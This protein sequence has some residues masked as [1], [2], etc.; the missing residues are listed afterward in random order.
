MGGA[1]GNR[2]PA[3]ECEGGKLLDRTTV[4]PPSVIGAA[5]V[6]HGF[7][8]ELPVHCPV[9]MIGISQ[10]VTTSLKQNIEGQLSL[11]RSTSVLR[12]TLMFW[13]CIR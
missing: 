9:K 11:R 8:A 6:P 10:P 1:S 5:S 13:P 2:G 12:S 7:A 4:G 3:V